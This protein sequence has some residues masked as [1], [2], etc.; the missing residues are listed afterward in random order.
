MV[1]KKAMEMDF[2]VENLWNGAP[3]MEATPVKFRLS[4][5]LVLRLENVE[6]GA[7]DK[8]NPSFRVH[9]FRCH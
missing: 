8:N 6:K 1:K 9:I 3:C 7:G 2:E 5:Y 4:M